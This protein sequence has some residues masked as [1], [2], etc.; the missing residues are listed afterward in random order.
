MS[1]LSKKSK[2][3]FN[4]LGH[5]ECS[6]CLSAESSSFKWSIF[7]KHIFPCLSEIFIG[8]IDTRITYI[9]IPWGKG[10]LYIDDT[11]ETDKVFVFLPS[12][13]KSLCKMCF[14]I[15]VISFDAGIIEFA[16]SL[17]DN[18]NL[19]SLVFFDDAHNHITDYMKTLMEDA[20]KELESKNIYS[21][22]LVLSSGAQRG[23]FDIEDS[24]E[25][26]LSELEEEFSRER[27]NV[28][29]MDV[30]KGLSNAV[31]LFP[32]NR[33]IFY[34]SRREIKDKLEKARREAN[35][36]SLVLQIAALDKEN[37]AIE[38]LKTNEYSYEIIETMEKFVDKSFAEK[39]LPLYKKGKNCL[40][41]EI[42]NR[43][44]RLIKEIDETFK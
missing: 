18:I 14:I 29:K 26:N 17:P 27:Y 34:Q 5:R 21:K 31:D 9:L 42:E 4:A 20:D 40:V 38:Y 35:N 22:T 24:E 44:E 13:H 32:S 15:S 39:I 36:L 12:K 37:D 30:R 3:I 2:E 28:L 33:H 19:C 8:K 23:N 10:S 25:Q 16:K 43:T 11:I 7:T 1:I 6:L 41:K